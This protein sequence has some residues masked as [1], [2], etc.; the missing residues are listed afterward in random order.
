PAAGSAP[1]AGAAAPAS[2]ASP[3]APPGMR[4]LDD[5]MKVVVNG[6]FC[7]KCHIVADFTPAGS[8]RAKAPNLA[9]VYR[10]VRPEYA[11]NWIANPKMILPYTAMPVNIPYQDPPAI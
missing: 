3:P 1:P 11:R 6:N 7:V 4:R 9:D 8:N 2:A 10:R 5:A